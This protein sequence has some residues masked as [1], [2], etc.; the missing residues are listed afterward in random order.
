M[1]DPHLYR[2]IIHAKALSAT[3]IE[4]GHGNE[5]FTLP[6]LVS[7]HKLGLIVL[8]HKFK[9]QPKT[10]GTESGN[11]LVKK[12]NPIK[13]KVTKLLARPKTRKTTQ[14]APTKMITPA[15][16]SSPRKK[17]QFPRYPLSLCPP[18]L[19]LAMSIISTTTP[20]IPDGSPVLNTAYASTVIPTT[21]P[22]PVYLYPM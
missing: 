16:R 6:H 11:V 2:W 17:K 18:P 8:P 20:N 9:L 5:K 4:Q 14:K 22:P 15:T 21:T 19:P 7:L 12:K 1:E 13:L 10:K 3:I